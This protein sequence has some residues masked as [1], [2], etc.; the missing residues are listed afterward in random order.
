MA[1]ADND[2]TVKKEQTFFCWQIA[3]LCF[4]HTEH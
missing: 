3:T 2:Q 4:G 1:K